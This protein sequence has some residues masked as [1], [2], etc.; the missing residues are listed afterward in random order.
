MR[1]TNT[2]YTKRPAV[3]AWEQR[4]CG[5]RAMR[6]A[7]GIDYGVAHEALKQ[8]GRLDKGTTWMHQIEDAA[9]K[10]G[11]TFR[12]V[13]TGGAEAKW[14]SMAAFLKDHRKGRF[15]I[16]RSGHFVA[17]INGTVHDWATGT[18]PRTKVQVAIEVL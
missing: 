11:R 3:Y 15:V 5:V 7:F 14:Y 1:K 2:E 17:V 12:R 13:E 4:D 18:G 10:M 6:I 16:L 8:E 9:T